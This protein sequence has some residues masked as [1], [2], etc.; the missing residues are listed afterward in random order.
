MNHRGTNAIFHK[1]ILAVGKLREAYDAKCLAKGEEEVQ[2]EEEAAAK[3]SKADVGVAAQ[4]TAEAKARAYV[5]VGE[6]EKEHQRY[7]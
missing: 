4:S 6:E 2:R 3:R 1:S 7:D 5:C